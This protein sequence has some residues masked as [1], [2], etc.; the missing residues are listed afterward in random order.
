MF[1]GAIHIHSRYSDGELTL[2][3]L[4][5][6][7]RAEGCA[8][9]AMTDHAESFHAESL[10]R[11]VAE[12]AALSTPDFLMIPGLEFACLNRMHILGIGVPVLAMTREPEPVIAHIEK[13]GGISV[14]AHP[15]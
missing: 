6:V 14:I 8:F 2:P 5:D 12:C 13:H 7:Y 4:R 1:K 15:L 10:E 9:V 3:E 11:Y